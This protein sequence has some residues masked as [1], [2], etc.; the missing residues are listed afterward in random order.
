MH[1]AVQGG[2]YRPITSTRMEFGFFLLKR[3]PETTKDIRATRRYDILTI[4]GFSTN[5]RFE[6]IPRR[7]F[8]DLL[9]WEIKGS[10]KSR[11]NF[12]IY[13]E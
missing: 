2:K 5:F 12:G 4:H 11:R 6:T 8:I 1:G 9:G 7:T 10:V 13:G 3:G